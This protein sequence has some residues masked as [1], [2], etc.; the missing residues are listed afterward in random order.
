[1]Q[2]EILCS[3]N[4]ALMTDPDRLPRPMAALA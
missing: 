1:M 2:R 3:N 4:E